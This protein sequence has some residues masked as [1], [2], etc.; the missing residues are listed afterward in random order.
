MP[1]PQNQTCPKCGAPLSPK[2][3]ACPVCG[4]VGRPGVALWT[5]LLVVVGL[6]AGLIGACSIMMS[7]SPSSPSSSAIAQLTGVVAILVP[8]VMLAMLIRAV[9]K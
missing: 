4:T 8:I 7:G 6:P 9:R 2:G 1:P 5:V 3:L